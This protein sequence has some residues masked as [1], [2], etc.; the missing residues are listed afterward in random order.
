AV[1]AL[2]SLRCCRTRLKTSKM[3]MV[4]TISSAFRVMAGSKKLA[5][6][7]SAKY[8]SQAEESTR[9]TSGPARA[10]RGYRCPAGTRAWSW[11]YAPEPARSGHYDAGH[12]T[13]VP[14]R[15]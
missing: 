10:K 1:H 15:A 4:G 12:G 13:C 5:F 14:G 6:G 11:H 8:S 3:T 7:P 2:F 9:F